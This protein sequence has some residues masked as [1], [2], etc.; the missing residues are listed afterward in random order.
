MAE[1]RELSRDYWSA[2]PIQGEW[3][4]INRYD[5]LWSGCEGQ[6]AV[7]INVGPGPVDNPT[8]LYCDHAEETTQRIRVVKMEPVPG[9]VPYPQGVYEAWKD[10][11]IPV[12]L[13]EAWVDKTV[14]KRI[15]SVPV[16]VDVIKIELQIDWDKRT[17]V[18]KVVG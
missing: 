14:V 12:I 18:P 7:L 16:G 9:D 4:E 6:G 15:V 5:R 11:D 2:K 1:K 13:R 8:R 17:V 3:F 10:K